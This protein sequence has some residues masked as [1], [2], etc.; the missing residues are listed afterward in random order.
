LE[1]GRNVLGVFID[2]SKAFDTLDHSLLLKKLEIYGVRGPTH[3][4][5]ASNFTD[6]RQYV[7]FNSTSSDTFAIKYGIPQGSIL[8]PLLFLIYVNDIIICFLDQNVKFYLM[9]TIKIYSSAAH[10]KNPLT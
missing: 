1:N 5:I 6:R 7:Q 2:L 4:L 3:S 9:L 10:P 8:G